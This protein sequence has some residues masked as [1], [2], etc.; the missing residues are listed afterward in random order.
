MFESLKARMAAFV[1]AVIA[2][3]SILFC[4]VAYWKMKEAMTEAIYSQV[5]QAAIAKVSFVSEWVSS[6][7]MVVASVLG[8]FGSGD[9]KPILDQAKEAGGFDDMYVGEPNKKM[10]QF[11]GATLA[12]PDY[13]PTVRPWY[14]AANASQEAIA[15]PPYIDASPSCRSSPLPRPGAMAAMSSRSR[16]AMFS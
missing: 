3:I 5:D 2:V 11:S 9:L 1:L 16:E 14:V 8:R 10:T 12:P 6:R 15:S 7:Q 4:G 13:D